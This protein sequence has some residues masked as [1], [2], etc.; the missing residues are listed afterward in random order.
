MR[1]ALWSIRREGGVGR[2]REDD[3]ELLFLAR[4]RSKSPRRE[5]KGGRHAHLAE[6]AVQ[7]FVQRS[8]AQRADV[9]GPM[10][11]LRDG[12]VLDRFGA[13]PAQILILA[14]I[15]VGLKVRLRLRRSRRV[16]CVLETGINAMGFVVRRG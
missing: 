8:Q 6:R 15:V 13:Y 11:A 16:F 3:G 2:E 9:A 7:L 1:D 4:V 10:V 14:G 12:I 5:H